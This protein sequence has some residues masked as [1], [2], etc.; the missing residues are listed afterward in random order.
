MQI[1][2]AVAMLLAFAA[3]LTSWAASRPNVVILF[4]DQWRAAATGY[5][6]DPNVK[7]PNLDRFA[8]E[9]VNFTHAVSGCPVCSPCR[10]SILTGQ[11]PWTHGVFLN[12]VHLSDDAVTLAKVM[13]SAGYDT[14]YI[15]KWHLNGRGRAS[16]IPPENR[17]GFQ[18]WK[19]LECTHA[20][21]NSPYFADGPMRLMWPGYDGAAQAKDAIAYIKQHAKGDKPFLLFLAWGPPH[22]PYNTAPAEYKA[23]YE[24][25]KI[26]LR[27]NV[28]E[29]NAEKTRQELAGYYAHCSA[30]DRSLGEIRDALAESG[31]ADDTLVI[32]SADHGDMLGSHGMERKQKP[33]DESVR[34]PMLWHWPTGL[35]GAGKRLDVPMDSEDVMPTILGLCGIEIPKTVDGIDFA[36][37]MKGGANPNPEEAALIHCVAPFGEWTRKVGGREYRG[38][39]TVR[40]TYVRGLD[41]PWLL[42][43]DEADPYQEHNLVNQPESAALRAKLDA[44]LNE[45]LKA[46]HDE[47]LPAEKYIAK[48]GW[49]VDASGTVPIR[50]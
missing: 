36:G 30:L 31:I 38:L 10:A 40:Y 7:T 11:R 16:Y 23:M 44:L 43:D 21:N 47:F 9:S 29:E 39:R 8:G 4:A 27:P 41:G 25:A 20:Y 24:A 32:F 37:Y 14:G 17:Q 1:G 19:A 3:P 13:A 45:R 15:G 33:Y 42:F 2:R 18:Y 34:V 49:Q 46:G 5:A 35:G 22:N 50:Q 48:W 6:G 26:Q 28:P 12:D